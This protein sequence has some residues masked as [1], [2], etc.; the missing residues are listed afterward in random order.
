M[1]LRLL[2]LLSVLVIAGC[3][4][5]PET[6]PNTTTATS[7]VSTT[8]TS[9][10][11]TQGE[12]QST[13]TTE[14][15]VEV[16]RLR[17]DQ[18]DDDALVCE[19]YDLINRFYVDQV[20]AAELA[21]AA[22]EAVVNLDHEPIAGQLTCQV[23][24]AA[25]EVVCE[26]MAEEGASQEV[27]V[28]ATLNG[29]MSALDPNSAYLSPEALAILEE[30]QSGE[31]EGIGALVASED[32]TAED[33]TATPC[34]V[35][36]STCQ[37]VVISTFAEGPADRA[38]VEPGDIF[39]AVDG[40]LIEGW[41]VDEVTAAVRG[42]AGT[43]VTLTMDR[44]G[45]LIDIPIMRASISVPVVETATVGST[46]YLRLNLFT[47]R[48][49]LQFHTALEGLLDDGIDQ[50]VLDLRDN[51][52]GAL[53]ATVAIASE[54]LTSGVVVRTEAPS[55][56]DIYEVRRGGIATDPELDVAVLVNR[57]SASASEVL[58]GA[59]KE[60]GRA[61]VIGENT[62][63][64]NTVQQ[65]FGLSNGGALKLT[66]ARWVTAAGTDFGGD[67]ITPD[68]AAE[69]PPELTPDE[70]VSEVAQLA[71]WSNAA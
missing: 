5:G 22:A 58:S 10:S 67:G 15:V 28:E 45:Q 66:V 2:A 54:F 4:D 8:T 24:A 50:L 30:D 32:L 21:D 14:T 6:V 53:D 59:L 25:F 26:A 51:P 46:G 13:A 3:V 48:S 20:A 37:L 12:G 65:R 63:G 42:P 31:V 38:G 69:L 9:P 62:F 19:A 71:G 47:D 35:I 64:K 68:V 1:R 17:C 52:G 29:M 36:S 34:P 16:A 57:G 23:P 55:D 33:P 49:D 40:E 61:V 27:A 39:I 56:E 7:A 11:T 60:A 44:D 43:R 18:A 41:T 70:L